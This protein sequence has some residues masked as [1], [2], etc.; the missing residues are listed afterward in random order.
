MRGKTRDNILSGEQQ[1][2]I[3]QKAKELNE[4]RQENIMM[5]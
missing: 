1:M 4:M 2:L 3:A 5:T